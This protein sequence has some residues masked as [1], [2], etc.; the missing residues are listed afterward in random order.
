MSFQPPLLEPNHDS[1]QRRRLKK[2]ERVN[3]ERI[4]AAKWKKM[5]RRSPGVNSGFTYL[6]HIL[7]PDGGRPGP[8]SRRDAVVAASVIQWLGTNCGLSLIWDCERK[9]DALRRTDDE[10][11]RRPS[12]FAQQRGDEPGVTRHIE[13]E[14]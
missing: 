7:T 9:I 4:Y 13:L 11:I 10:K 6:E 3:P 14:D 12:L 1:L 8:V 5:N 2:Y